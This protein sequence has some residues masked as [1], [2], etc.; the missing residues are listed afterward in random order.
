MWNIFT[1]IFGSRNQRLLREYTR[2]FDADIRRAGARTALYMV[3]PS[4]ARERDFDGVSRSYA[5]AASDVGGLLFAVGEAW[6]AAWSRDPSIALYGPDGF[7]PTPAASYLAALVIV[8][9]AFGVSVAGLPA[10]GISP[11]V[12]AVL[13]NAWHKLRLAQLRVDAY[14]RLCAGEANQRPAVFQ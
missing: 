4:R 10:P 9:K 1:S 14:E 6:R 2:R 5:A 7:H 3:W 11:S 12:A 8:H 13:Q